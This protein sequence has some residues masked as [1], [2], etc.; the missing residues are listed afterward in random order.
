MNRISHFTLLATVLALAPL[1]ARGQEQGFDF[2]GEAGEA[3]LAY[4]RALYNALDAKDAQEAAAAKEVK[5]SLK[6][7]N[8]VSKS[9]VSWRKWL[10]RNLFTSEW[11]ENAQARNNDVK[12]M[13]YTCSEGSETLLDIEVSKNSPEAYLTMLARIR[14]Y[15]RT[16]V[17]GN[18]TINQMYGNGFYARWHRY[19]L[20]REHLNNIPKALKDLKAEEF[21]ASAEWIISQLG[22]V[23]KRY[24]DLLPREELRKRVELHDAVSDAWYR[25]FASTRTDCDWVSSVNFVNSVPF[26]KG[27]IIARAQAI[28][29]WSKPLQGKNLETIREDI[30]RYAQFLN[31]CKANLAAGSELLQQNGAKSTADCDSFTDLVQ[32]DAELWEALKKDYDRTWELYKKVREDSEGIGAAIQVSPK[33]YPHLWEVARAAGV[34]SNEKD[35]GKII[36]VSMN[37][38]GKLLREVSIR[39][40]YPVIK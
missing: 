2:S 17:A 5:A 14:R 27:E 40:D 13:C 29:D 39:A 11:I 31:D 33:R 10:K 16:K 20:A 30:G 24:G 34:D 4:Q 15:A 21:L 23:H 12:G 7:C 38:L 18:Y 8:H 36:I 32:L 28:Y 9:M 26:I 25:T 22:A 37:H 3:E 1:G 6:W 35:I 19:A